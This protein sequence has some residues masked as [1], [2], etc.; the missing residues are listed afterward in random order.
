MERYPEDTAMIWIPPL[1]IGAMGLSWEVDQGGAHDARVVLDDWAKLDEF[2][3]KLPYPE[4]DPRFE[5]L[6]V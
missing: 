4:T 5:V 3:S 2:V 1:D 6:E